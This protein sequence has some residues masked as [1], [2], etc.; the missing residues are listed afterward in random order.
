MSS[1]KRYLFTG[2]WFI[3]ALIIQTTVLR[4]IAIL[5]YSPNLIMCS[6]VVF[7]FLYQEKVGLVYGVIFGLILDA[8]T[9]VYIGPSAISFTL[10]YMFITFIRHFFNHEKLLPEI[11]LSA[12]STLVNLCIMWVFYSLSGHPTSIMIMVKALPVLL[13]YNTVV[14]IILHLIFVRGVIKHKR[15]NKV[16]GNYKVSSSGIKL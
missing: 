5:G 16:T 11:L 3:V 7:S 6:V 13:V 8:I 12:V 1:N 10:A 15:D 4:H 14:V 9:A 2:I